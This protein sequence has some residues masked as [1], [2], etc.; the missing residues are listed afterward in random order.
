MIRIRYVLQCKAVTLP[1][2]HQT[3]QCIAPLPDH[4]HARL[5]HTG[6]STASYELDTMRR[7][8]KNETSPPRATL[9][10]SRTICWYLLV[11]V[12]VPIRREP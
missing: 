2:S 6:A 3:N 5:G 10:G 8:G 1:L 7:F 11:T 12:S 9:A 4:T